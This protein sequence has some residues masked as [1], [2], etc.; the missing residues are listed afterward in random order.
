MNRHESVAYREDVHF[1]I[2]T[3][4]FGSLRLGMGSFQNDEFGFYTRYCYEG[5]AECVVIE[6][7]NKM[8]VVN[9]KDEAATKEIYE[10]LLEKLKK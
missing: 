5:F 2:R 9:G 6:V 4:G 10:T 7:G 3:N 1:G 8:L